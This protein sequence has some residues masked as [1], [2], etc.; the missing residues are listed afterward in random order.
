[1]KKE[2]LEEAGKYFA[3]NSD[4]IININRETLEYA[5]I[6]EKIAMDKLKSKWEHLYTFGYPQEPFPKNY[7]NDLNNIKVGLYE[8]AKWQ[9]ERMYSEEEVLEIVQTFNDVCERPNKPHQIK[10]WF[11]QFKKK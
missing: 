7:E 5:S 11:E 6:I 10:N 4:L 1:M 2:T 9:Q 8:G 3:D